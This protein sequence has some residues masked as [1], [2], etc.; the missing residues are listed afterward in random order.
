D[1]HE[2]PALAVVAANGD[3]RVAPI[4]RRLD[5]LRQ[6][7]GK[8]AE[9][10][11]HHAKPGQPARRA[12]SRKQAIAYAAWWANDLDGGEYGLVIWDV[13]R[14][15]GGQGGLGGGFVER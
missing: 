8:C 15:A 3:A 12:G 6:H 11:V 14:K 7:H 5:L 1:V 2:R 9:H 13:R 4:A 10:A